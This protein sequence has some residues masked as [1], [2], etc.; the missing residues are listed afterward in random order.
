[1]PAGAASTVERKGRS[2][3]VRVQG[4]VVITTARR[5]FHQLRVVC[6]RRDVRTVTLDF[7]NA[8]RLDSS[9]LAVISLIAKRLERSGKKLELTELSDTHKAAL[10]L[11]PKQEPEPDA[12][13]PPAGALEKLGGKVLDA[14]SGARAL[15]ALIAETV[16]QSIAVASRRKKLPA[17]SLGHQ[18]ATMGVDGLFIVGLLSFLLG[19]TMAF[20][21]A[22]Q[23]QRFGAGVFVADMISVSMVREIG[24]LMTAVILTG[25]TGAAIAAE[26]GTMRVR[27]EIDAL[28]TM[29]INPVRFLIVPRLAAITIVGPALSLMGMFI[30]IAGG[31]LVAWIALDMPPI[32]FW[33]RITERVTALDFLHGIG[34]SLVF[35]WIIGIAGSHL[36]MR[37]GGDAMSVGNATTRT[38]VVSILAI[39]VVDAIFATIST[40]LRYT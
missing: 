38:V 26:L 29:G 36:G 39:I 10:E 8:G 21:G 24:P 30:G 19:V 27:S 23:L 7:S 31:M 14:G 37:A 17:G 12:A 3:V 11:L 34:K 16:R 20:Q 2:A 32:M 28:S 40:V 1:M 9:G 5:L 25:R 33:Q 4:D 18:V 6:R 35:A 13:E 22:V 15:F